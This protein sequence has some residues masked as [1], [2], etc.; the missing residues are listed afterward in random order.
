MP[1][2]RSGKNCD[3]CIP[4]K[5]SGKN[6]KP[7]TPKSELDSLPP[8]SA[9]N[10]GILLD[11]DRPITEQN[12]RFYILL[13]MHRYS[14]WYSLCKS[15]D[16]KAAVSFFEFQKQ[17]IQL[18]GIPKTKRTDKDRLSQAITSEILQKFLWIRYR[19]PDIPTPTGL[20]ER[21]GT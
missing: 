15:T 20:V 12:F 13:S 18:N 7:N 17:C 6:I 1:F 10:K 2:K 11:V 5:R 8:S 19:R 4:C 9:P 14:N 21:R 16:G 3:S